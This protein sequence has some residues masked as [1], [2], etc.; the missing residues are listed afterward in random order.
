M[1]IFRFALVVAGLL[2]SSCLRAQDAFA[3]KFGMTPAEVASVTEYAPYKTFSNGDLETYEATFAGK[4]Q[5]FQFFFDDNQPRK[6]RRIG[7]Y[8]YE[9]QDIAA[10]AGEWSKLHGTLAG[11]FGEVGTPRNALDATASDAGE[12]GF[13]NTAIRDVQSSGKTQMA[14]IKQRD[15]AFVFANFRS[16]DVQGETYYLVIL[17]ID[18]PDPATEG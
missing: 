11:L 4:K 12:S 1:G 14:P 2:A 17:Y 3:W 5:N 8:L 10:A 6:L 13:R 9:G 15:D 18:P 7:I 16:V